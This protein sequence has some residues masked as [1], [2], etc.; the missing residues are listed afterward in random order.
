VH[1][2]QDVALEQRVPGAGAELDLGIG[3]SRV[4]RERLGEAG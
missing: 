2:R 4:L 3:E 1:D